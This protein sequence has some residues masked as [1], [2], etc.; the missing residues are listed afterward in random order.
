MLETI[1]E[2]IEEN[3]NGNLA[4][5]D[6]EIAEN[7]DYASWYAALAGFRDALRP[8]YSKSCG[9]AVFQTK[10]TR[11][12]TDDVLDHHVIGN[13]A[14]LDFKR[15]GWGNALRSPSEQII[16]LSRWCGS[17]GTRFIYAA[18]PCKG[19]F[20]P[21]IAVPEETLN[22][23]TQ[24]CPQWRKMLREITEAGVELL[25]LLEPLMLKKD[26]LPLYTKDHYI[27]PLC[28]RLVAHEIAEYLQKTTRLPEG[29]L[30]LRS[31]ECSVDFSCPD[32]EG[33]CVRASYPAYSIKRP[34]GGVLSYPNADIGLFGNCN[35]Q[36]FMSDSAGI[37]ENL[38]DWLRVPVD[39]MGRRLPFCTGGRH[40][41]PIYGSEGFDKAFLERLA[42]K[43]AVVYLGFPTAAFVRSS[44]FYNGFAPPLRLLYGSLYAP[45][46]TVPLD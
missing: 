1:S 18:L 25:D 41:L 36:A 31:E 12:S 26:E 5:F 44:G 2:G 30:E 46:S 11:L 8:Y 9:G 37:Y 22:G 16:E 3:R 35:L 29:S 19:V 13:L 15:R 42:Q 10:R 4:R 6:R 7:G 40:L 24:N 14:P 38:L 27:S 17:H 39:Y 32:G 28:A 45:W 33:G 34:E 20:Y 21:E 43:D 23:K